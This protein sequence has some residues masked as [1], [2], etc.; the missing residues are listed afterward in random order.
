MF[1][2]WSHL[3]G[4]DS[5]IEPFRQI[6][7]SPSLMFWVEKNT[8]AHVFCIKATVLSTSLNIYRV[9]QKAGMWLR[10]ANAP[11]SFNVKPV[12]TRWM[13]YGNIYIQRLFPSGRY[14]SR[15][16][17]W[18]AC[19]HVKYVA[20]GSQ[21]FPS[22][23]EETSRGI[24]LFM[25]HLCVISKPSLS[26]SGRVTF[27]I[28]YAETRECLEFILLDY[29]LW[30]SLTCS[31]KSRCV[32]ARKDRWV[33]GNKKSRHMCKWRVYFWPR[34]LLINTIFKQLQHCSQHNLTQC[35]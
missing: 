27:I 30:I 24:T 20:F 16:K 1:P 14:L 22:S 3:W 7:S 35:V 29:N 34:R 33:P 10:C 4:E 13:K 28:V 26:Q 8:P 12:L 32:P 21:I 2:K 23:V 5:L 9:E 31:W 17:L 25:F 6:H 15:N 11:P 18:C 19:L